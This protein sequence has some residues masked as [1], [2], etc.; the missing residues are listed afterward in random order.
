[1]YIFAYLYFGYMILSAFRREYIHALNI[2]RIGGSGG[3]STANLYGKRFEE[4]TNNEGRLLQCGYTKQF[5]CDSKYHYLKKI[6]ENKTVSFVSQRGLKQYL[7]QYHNM[8]IFRY[9]DE[10]Y[11][12]QYKD[13]MNI[14]KILEKKTQ[15]VDGSVE[16]KLW[17]G[18]SLK[19]EYELLL[20]D[21]FKVEYAFCVSSF[22]KE[23]MVSSEKKYIILNTILKEHNITILFGENKSYF[24]TLDKWIE[25]V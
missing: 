16:T 20:G 5:I 15:M 9:P 3:G 25:S 1:M 8:E 14:L 11:L 17:S 18:P 21:R 4:Y 2:R 6:F 10:A 24:D 12:I 22:L 13:G 19:R 7:K 23:K